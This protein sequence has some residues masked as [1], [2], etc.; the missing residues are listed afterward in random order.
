MCGCVLGSRVLSIGVLEVM[1]VVLVV[2]VV[3]VYSNDDDDDDE[4]CHRRGRSRLIYSA[5]RNINLI[6]APVK[7]HIVSFRITGEGTS[8]Q[9]YLKEVVQS[10]TV[11][12]GIVV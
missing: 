3:R 5:V 9:Q 12:N 10:G 2:L 8:R 4:R 1:I 7:F 6:N 11:L